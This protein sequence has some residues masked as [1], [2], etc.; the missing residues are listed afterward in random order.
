MMSTAA[1]VEPERLTLTP[2]GPGGRPFARWRALVT[3]LAVLAL[4]GV[5]VAL[6]SD[7]APGILGSVTREVTAQLD[8]AAPEARTSV[9]EAV[10]GTRVEE[11]DVQGH[12]LLWSAVTVLVGLASWS[13][14]SLIAATALV[15][16]ASTGLELVQEELAPSRI[17]ERSDLLANGLG[18]AL[19]FAIVLLVTTGSGIPARLRR[20]ARRRRH[21]R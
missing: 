16:V 11:R 6:L 17:T 15:V 4:V 2:L 20:R 14:R 12:I 21:V 9:N 18:I 5:V 13:W 10:A 19:G 8:R 1:P 3:V 7:R